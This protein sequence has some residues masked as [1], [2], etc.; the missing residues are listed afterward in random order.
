MP[1][2]DKQSL[3]ANEFIKKNKKLLFEKFACDKIYKPRENPI[4]LFMAGSPGAGKTEYSKALI[5]IAK[6][7]F[8]ILHNYEKAKR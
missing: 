4:L 5:E 8:I 3:A 6:K 7:S 2:S 1:Q